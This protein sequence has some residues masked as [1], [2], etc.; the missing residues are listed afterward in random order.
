MTLDDLGLPYLE[1][2]LWHFVQFSVESP[3][4]Y[5]VAEIAIVRMFTNEFIGR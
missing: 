4:L 5:G 2:L 3:G 1:I